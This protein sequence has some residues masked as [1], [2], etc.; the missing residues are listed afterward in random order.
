VLHKFLILGKLAEDV[1]GPFVWEGGGFDAKA[2]AAST[3]IAVVV[4]SAGIV[5]ADGFSSPGIE[6]GSIFLRSKYLVDGISFRGVVVSTAVVD[7]GTVC[8][9]AELSTAVAKS[10]RPLFVVIR[11]SLSV[12][13]FDALTVPAGTDDD[14]LLKKL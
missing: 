10:I 12:L 14:E 9:D 6:V 5:S 7:V 4:E 2:T 11:S 8:C 3:G 13:P 1:S